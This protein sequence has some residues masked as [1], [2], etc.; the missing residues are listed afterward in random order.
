VLTG[1]KI[2]KE[3]T[4]CSPGPKSKSQP[5][6]FVEAELVVPTAKLVRVLQI[7]HSLSTGDG[8]G[9]SKVKPIYAGWSE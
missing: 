3:K 5:V 9:L 1:L 8:L 7:I 2:D 4:R 6:S